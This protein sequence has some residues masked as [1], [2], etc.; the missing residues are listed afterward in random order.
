MTKAKPQD[1][2]VA[3]NIVEEEFVN[4]NI[5]SSLSTKGRLLTYNEQLRAS[6]EN[7]IDFTRILDVLIN[8]ND[9]TELL[10]AA[11]KLVNYQ[12]DSAYLVYLQKYS[13][14]DFYLIFLNRLLQLHK[15]ENVTLAASEQHNELYHEYPN[16]G[17]AGYFIFTTDNQNSGAYYTE[18][19]TGQKLFYLDFERKILRFNSQTLTDLL[20]INYAQQF[21]YEVIEEI[22]DLL[23]A[24]GRYLKEDYGFDVDFSLLDPSNNAFYEIAHTQM[25]QKPLDRLFIKAADAGFMLTNGL[26]N[27][28]SLVLGDIKLT[29]CEQESQDGLN[30]KWG[31]M[32]DDENQEFSWF[33]MLFKYEFLHD[34]YLENLADLELMCDNRYF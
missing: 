28:A 15:N 12:L 29:I 13:L 33:K 22:A 18:K 21:E 9:T 2:E 26:N 34:W 7:G 17:A 14:L 1:L 30:T 23:L 8:T 27:E 16:L 5:E 31:I 6:L 24:L 10:Q 11:M 20:V 25:P 19:Q 32:I 3:T 4:E